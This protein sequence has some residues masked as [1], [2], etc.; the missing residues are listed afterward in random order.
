MVSA[1]LAGEEGRPGRPSEVR[2]HVALAGGSGASRPT[3]RRR[4]ALQ[5]RLDSRSR[6]GRPVLG[7]V[8]RHLAHGALLAAELARTVDEVDAARLARGG[9]REVAVR[10]RSRQPAAS[11]MWREMG[12]EQTAYLALAAA[13]A[14]LG[15]PRRGQGQQRRRWRG[16]SHSAGREGGGRGEQVEGQ[17]GVW[18]GVGGSLRRGVLQEVRAAAVGPTAQA[19]RRTRS[20]QS[21]AASTRE[22][23]EREGREEEGRRR[24]PATVR[25]DVVPSR[26]SS[27]PHLPF[28]PRRA[29][30]A[31]A[32]RPTKRIDDRG[33]SALFSSSAPPL[34]RPPA[35]PRA[36]LSVAARTRPL[37]TFPRERT[38]ATALLALVLL[39][40]QQGARS[41]RARARWREKGTNRL[42]KG[43]GGAAT[44]RARVVW[45]AA[46]ASTKPRRSAPADQPFLRPTTAGQRC[47]P[48]RVLLWAEGRHG[49]LGQPPG[50]RLGREGGR[51][52]DE[53]QVLGTPPPPRCRLPRPWCRMLLAGC[54]EPALCERVRL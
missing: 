52:R 27:T 40:R 25:R 49:G 19:T 11:A 14:G 4:A 54:A 18:R 50:G 33:W 51:K 7:H 12:S 47:F 21:R 43:R 15:R 1:L 48:G 5:G 22:R 17:G 36:A 6:L 24:E 38:K 28:F 32:D 30:V 13:L 31:R 46:A 34:L 10:A 41:G 29:L 53:P 45:G 26:P 23:V 35:R 2:P 9:G 42:D 39:E 37:E 3:W 44:A 16:R 20:D 8:G